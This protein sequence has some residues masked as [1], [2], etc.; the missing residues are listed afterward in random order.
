MTAP[1]TQVETAAEW[2]VGFQLASAPA[3][4]VELSKVQIA[5]MLAAMLA[6][7]AS[8]AGACVWRTLNRHATPGP[9]TT[10]PHGDRIGLWD[11]LFLHASYANALELDDFHFRGHL[12]PAAVVVP[13]T[14]GEALGASGAE[15]LRAQII[16]NEL[17]G[18]L[19]WA[20]TAEIRHGHQRSYLVRFAAA[21]AAAALLRLDRAPFARALA[22]AMTQPEMPLH[23]GEFSPD[24][25]V[26]SAA[27]SVVEGVRAAFLAA[28]GLDAATDI[29]EHRAGF[30]RQFT[31]HRAVPNPFV[32]FDRAWCT[33]ALSFKR[34]AACAYASGCVDAAVELRKDPSFDP[35]QITAITVDTALTAM[36]MEHLAR[37]HEAG[38]L[39]P[40]NVQFSIV[41]CVAAALA[42]GDL[43]GF[44]F[45]PDAFRALAPRVRQLES[46][47]RL[48]HDWTFTIEQLRGI[49]DGMGPNSRSADI[50]Q[51]W[52]TSEAFRAMFGS[53]RALGLRDIARLLALPA[54]DRRYFLSRW[55]RSLRR[56]VGRRRGAAAEDAVGD[57][58]RLSWRMGG[59]VTVTLQDGRRISAERVLPTG[60]AG[61]PARR[62]V[63]QEKLLAE[64]S[65]VLGPDRCAAL[66]SAIMTLEGTPRTRLAALASG[67]MGGTDAAAD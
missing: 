34:Y 52:R 66:W 2:A 19:G 21:A 3:D 24:T 23:P 56:F 16:A 58:R 18:R 27:P 4:V 47:T 33:H 8:A 63:V 51:F 37:P 20:I 6:G 42:L 65:L 43:R 41:R 17:G 60:M 11:A 31:M 22:I 55:T 59:R 57:L 54:A 40:V 62:D 35:D 49:E 25:K 48:Q 7:S 36:I 44:H 45:R 12:G 10:I 64:G 38:V 5:N 50:V 26:L 61:D 14:L 29:L 30:Y 9:C 67:E 53:V 39:T 28:E 15:A 32:Q 13:I 1:L 46:V